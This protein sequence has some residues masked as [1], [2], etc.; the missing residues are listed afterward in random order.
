MKANSNDNKEK[1]Q[2][3]CSTE[4]SFSYITSRTRK[5]SCILKVSHSKSLGSLMLNFRLLSLIS[6]K[7]LSM[8]QRV[9]LWKEPSDAITHVPRQGISDRK[10][11]SMQ[12][13]LRILEIYK[14]FA[15]VYWE[16][17]YRTSGFRSLK[18][19][20]RVRSSYLS[21]TALEI[22]FVWLCTYGSMLELMGS[23]A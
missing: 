21:G 14:A 13:S 3:R 9:R 18:W 15:W 11:R 16:L 19:N 1:S 8:Q 17:V 12:G 10:S 6:V 2:R 23:K 4:Q 7:Y 20:V 5:E 22:G